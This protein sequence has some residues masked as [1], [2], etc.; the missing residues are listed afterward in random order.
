M[1]ASASD[2]VGE[3]L[4]RAARVMRGDAAAARNVDA[5]P[6][7]VRLSFLGVALALAMDAGIM[8]LGV[9]QAAN[10]G[11]GAGFVAL[12]LLG[13]AN[14]AA[15]VAT[16]L[17]LTRAPAQRRRFPAWLLVQ[18]WG[19][20]VLAAVL[21][22]PKWIYVSLPPVAVEG[23]EVRGWPLVT[24]VIVLGVAVVSFVA[25]YRMALHMLAVSGVRAFWLVTAAFVAA[26]LA[27]AVLA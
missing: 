16:M 15:A 3:G 2:P 14:Y 18:N 23:A 5:T 26:A 21:L 12:V 25:H 13:F 4:A 1:S 6:A 7:A 9:A 27:T 17:V 19:E 24:V 22:V 8:S 11:R 10:V 20:A